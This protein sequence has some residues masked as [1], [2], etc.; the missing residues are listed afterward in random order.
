MVG[1]SFCLDPGLGLLFWCCRVGALDLERTGQEP[2]S[3]CAYLKIRRAVSIFPY[4]SVDHLG[5]PLLTMGHGVCALRYLIQPHQCPSDHIRSQAHL[6]PLRHHHGA[7]I[8]EGRHL[9]GTGLADSGCL[10]PFLG[11]LLRNSKG[12]LE[13]RSVWSSW[14]P[15]SEG[16]QHHDLD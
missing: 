14:I 5:M 13:P 9:T 16:L 4:L 12:V 15:V 11:G 1:P 7:D 6:V 10:G 3:Q 8:Q 2:S